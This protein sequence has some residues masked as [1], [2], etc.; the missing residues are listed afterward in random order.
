MST[1]PQKIVLLLSHA[2]NKY[3]DN[4]PVEFLQR[5]V[6]I[7]LIK[8]LCWKFAPEVICVILNAAAKLMYTVLEVV[9][10]TMPIHCIKI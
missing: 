8:T 5:V 2:F 6:Q 1:H 9:L 4:D 7:R 3:S 10:G